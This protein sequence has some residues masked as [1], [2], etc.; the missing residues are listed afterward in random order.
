L[1]DPEIPKIQHIQGIFNKYYHISDFL[2]L[3]SCIDKHS[4]LYLG[5]CK[6]NVWNTM[7]KSKFN[8]PLEI[9]NQRGRQSQTKALENADIFLVVLQKAFT[10]AISFTR[11]TIKVLW[12]LVSG[13]FSFVKGVWQESPWL[14]KLPWIRLSI[15]ALAAYLLLGKGLGF[16]IDLNNPLG[17]GALLIPSHVEDREEEVGEKLEEYPEG[18]T[19]V[20]NLEDRTNDLTPIAPALLKNPDVHTFIKRFEATAKEEMKIYGIPASIKMGQA[21]IESQAG[22]STLAAGSNNFFGIK[23]KPKCLGCTC[24]NYADDNKYDMFRVFDSA[25]ES[26]RAHST[27]LCNPRYSKLPLYGKD[28]KK[29]AHGLKK[30]GYATDPSYATKLINVIEKYNLT[31]LDQ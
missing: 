13:I 31:L 22:K 7:Y 10:F 25:W 27:L 19:I 8:I 21:I 18:S 20:S 12:A 26:W 16:S 6:Q 24:K 11:S 14:R 1:V 28:Y 9:S 30:A 29:W 17:K 3:N 2:S 15:L 4:V 23:C 5:S